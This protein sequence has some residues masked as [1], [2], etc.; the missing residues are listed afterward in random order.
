VASGHLELPDLRIEDEAAD[1]RDESR[2]VDS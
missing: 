2:D 1:G